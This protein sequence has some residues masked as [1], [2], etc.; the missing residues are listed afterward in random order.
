[1]I[2]MRK[3]LCLCLACALLAGMSFSAFGDN[4]APVAEN[5]EIRT[6]RG[7]AV[8][9]RLSATDPEGEKLK[10]E[11]TTPP[12]KG[13]LA[14][15]EDGKYTYTPAEGKKG[16]DYFG[17]KATDESGNSSHEA[18]VIIRIEKQKSKISYSDMSDNGAH[19][20]AVRLAEEEIFVG[21]CLGGEYLFSPDKAVSRG[22][23]LAMC[24][25]LADTRLL[26][27]VSRTGF[28]D[29]EDIPQWLRPY[30]STALMCAAISGEKTETGAV[31][32]PQRSISGHEA[33]VMLNNILELSDVHYVSAEADSPQW[34][35]QAV[36]NLSA[37]RIIDQGE[38][39]ADIL[40]RA[41][42]AEILLRAMDR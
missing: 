1:M 32:S 18:T 23:F 7:T 12:I 16:K 37:N 17:Y 34:A 29:D 27:G 30:V 41:E 38:A 33:T 39:T 13:E 36:M 9:G 20:S 15:S 35:A 14:L 3:I 5:L 24:M 19:Y 10:F 28:A 31:F 26:D 21:E 8:S 2:K 6:Y 11:I 4:G 22:E 42:A 25:K 40:T